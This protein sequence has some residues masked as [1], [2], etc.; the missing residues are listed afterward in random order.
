MKAIKTL[1]MAAL[2]TAV[3]PAA[4]VRMNWHRT[5]IQW[6]MWCELQQA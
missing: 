4:P 5:I 1:A 3:L 2:A 6:I